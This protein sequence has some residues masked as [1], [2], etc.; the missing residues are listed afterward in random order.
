[1]LERLRGVL[2][3]FR[4]VKDAMDPTT[5]KRVNGHVRN[6]IRRLGSVG[7]P[8]FLPFTFAASAYLAGN[9]HWN[10]R[11]ELKRGPGEIVFG[12]VIWDLPH[13]SFIE[14]EFHS[15]IR[16]NGKLLDITPR[17]DGEEQI[18]F[19]PDRERVVVWLD[20]TT[21]KS[22]SNVRRLGSVFVPT[23]T[24]IYR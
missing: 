17:R 13:M 4:A 15:V 23:R 9:C 10:T 21:L 18:L 14:A 22:W 7:Q 11:T 8:E 24:Q 12:W 1:M 19:V 5:P 20:A 16:R 6:F 3:Q 2:A